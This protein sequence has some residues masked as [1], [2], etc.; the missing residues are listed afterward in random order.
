MMDESERRIRQRLKDDFPHYAEKCLRIRTKT[1]GLKPLL[2][3]REQAYVH[4]RLEEQR[5][6]T[7]RVRALI[8]KA[9]QTGLSTYVAARGYH[10]TTHR[11]GV[12]AFLLTHRQDATDNLFGMVAR[13]HK[14]CPKPVK[15]AVGKANAKELNFSLLDSGYR[16]STAGAKETGRSETVQFFHGSEV[17][18]WA[19]ADAHV[20][21][22]LNAV[23]EADD[24]EVILESTA[25]GMAGVFYEMCME[26]EKGLGAFQLIFLPWFWHEEYRRTPPE[27]WAAPPKWG[28]YGE[29]HGLAPDQLFWA[30][31]K[32]RTLVKGTGDDPDEGPGW[33]FK[34]E[35]PATAAEAFQTSGAHALVK[36]ELVMKARRA[37]LPEPGDDAPVILGLDVARGGGD[38]SW[39]ID[40]R[41]RVLGR[42]INERR[43]TEDTMEIVGWTAQT[44]DR[45]KADMCFIDSGGNGAAIYDRLVEL[46]YGDR[47]TLVNFG[48][49]ASDPE[50]FANKR[51]EMW[52]LMRDWF[53]DE[54]G[55]D[56]PDDDLLHRHICGP[57]YK[58]DS[59]E[60]TILEKK[61]AIKTRLGFSPD[62]GDAAALT[63]AFPVQKYRSWSGADTAENEYDILN[64]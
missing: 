37:R 10:F 31:E 18:F 28:E 64:H 3:N 48:Q 7:G 14:H 39:M 5:R 24:T 30:I 19:H 58:E 6:A 1:A 17:A 51:A 21:G 46:G 47:L 60:R 15:P 16:V 61:E 38:L 59:N 29:L 11:K 52:V 35:Y 57:G 23:P 62:G 4:E 27:G 45:L 2:L 9:R 20:A 49:K 36:S 32:N 26:A 34:Q 44:I 42:L 41:R 13:Y 12:R 22:A 56:M 54:G 53:A 8:L 50:R 40:R 25:N 33:K 43:N 55:A 63:F